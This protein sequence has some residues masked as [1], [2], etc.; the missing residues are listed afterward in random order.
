MP[1]IKEYQ[2]KISSLKNSRKIT[3]SMKMI[4]SIKLQKT[5]KQFDATALY[6]AAAKNLEAALG[7]ALQ[8]E[9]SPVMRG[10]NKVSQIHI[11]QITGDRGLCGRFNANT[12]L[13]LMQ[14]KREEEQKGRELKFSCIGL[15]GASYLKR[16]SI[17]FTFFE[18]LVAH[19][20]WS[21]AK[22]MA[23][24]L[25]HDFL[26]GVS[27]E[28][29]FIYSKKSN[30]LIT[31]PVVER[32]LPLSHDVSAKNGMI[33]YILEDQ[34]EYMLSESARLIVQTRLYSAL[35]ESAVAEHAARMA[36]MDSASTNC[37]RLISQYT[38][39]RNRARQAVITTELNEIV[40]GKEA[41]ES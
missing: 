9:A 12:T 10:H 31:G 11:V 37:D 39:L 38:Q 41:L 32:V 30:S 14:K 34:P 8:N 27:H 13:A 23:D 18:G 24:K 3:G 33:D 15:R 4:S 16:R 28:V 17:D 6:R 40:T 5:S 35:I 1:S 26:A 22:K 7:A 2:R 20:D 25:I 21:T 29:W 19:P 36:A